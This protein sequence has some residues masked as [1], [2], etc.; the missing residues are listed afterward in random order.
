MLFKTRDKLIRAQRQANARA[1]ATLKRNVVD[2]TFEIDD[3]NVTFFSRPR[4]LD[5]LCFTVL[6]HD[7]VDR[8]I[9]FT[10]R[11]HNLDP[12]E[13]NGGEVEITDLRQNLERDVVFEIFAFIERHNFHLGL[14]RRAQ[15]MIGQHLL[16]GRLDRR[17]EDFAHHRIAEA[18]LENL[19]RHLAGSKTRNVDRLA[20]FRQPF[21]NALLNINCPDRDLEI[22]D[23]AFIFCLNDVH[24]LV[25][26]LLF[27]VVC[28]LQEAA[29]HLACS[30]LLLFYFAPPRW[31]NWCGRRDLNPHDFAVTRT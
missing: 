29:C 16:R 4:G 22:T 18:L 9:D 13:F 7:T 8:I 19:H 15:A 11:R 25:R 23:K 20:D 30:P 14:A 31:A 24:C 1:L 17:L 12:I 27:V 2:L 28:E 26:F 5:R 21:I 3:D 10:V 6:L